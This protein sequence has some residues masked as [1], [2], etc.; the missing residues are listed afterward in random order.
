MN[1]NIKRNSNRNIININLEAAQRTR[2]S[3]AY[4]LNNLRFEP[5]SR[6]YNVNFFTPA[7]LICHK[8][9]IINTNFLQTRKRSPSA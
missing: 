1:I 4:L 2:I 3:I 9:E 6:I 8:K 7:K 5:A